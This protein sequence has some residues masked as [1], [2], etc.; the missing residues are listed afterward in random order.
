[1]KI[2]EQRNAIIYARISSDREG[3]EYGV[4]RQE[5]HCRRLAERRGWQVV[6]VLVDN[7]ITGTGSKRRPGYE[8]MLDLLRDGAANAI[9]AV[10]DKRL[11]RNYRNAFALL[12]LIQEQDIAVEFTK[13][14][15]INMNTAEGRGIARR[16]AIDAQEESEEI[17][18]RVADAKK[19][20]V[21]DGT[22]R[23]GGRPFGYERDGVTLREDEAAYLRDATHRILAGESVR[24]ILRLW[25]ADG[26][27]TPAR[28]K[29]L[30]DGTRSEPISRSWTP[31]TLRNLL[32]RPR[33]AGHM[34]VATAVTKKRQGEIT[35]KAVWP[36]IVSEDEWRQ[37]RAVLENPV[38]RTTPGNAR[39]W[40]GGRLY[41]CGVCTGPVCTTGRG[42]GNGSVYTCGP[43][44]HIT[45]DAAAVDDHVERTVLGQVVWEALRDPFWPPPPEA[46]AGPPTGQLSARH[47]TLRAQLEALAE[48]FGDDDAD[49]ALYRVRARRITDEIK[50]VEQGIAEAVAASAAQPALLAGVDLPELVRRHQADTD[51]ALA[52][53]RETYSLEYRRKILQVLVVVTVRPGSSGRPPGWVPG[54]PYF[55][56][57]TVDIDWTGAA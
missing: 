15:A 34:E 33:N 53:W 10:S 40:L 8:Q 21:R 37:C 16:K 3:R 50:A 56:P 24:S 43:K 54:A 49:L 27:R 18:E 25:E 5:A 12:D 47:A 9:L 30:P 48:A 38:R 29:R 36:A 51:D 57:E 55:N 26:V 13:G 6:T 28:R 35:G 4:E 45:R 22:Y 42:S 17:G 52:W 32:F 7:D 31:S 14:G 2:T 19:D 23:G 39:R 41:L 1:M 11:N 44:R 46:P 20:N